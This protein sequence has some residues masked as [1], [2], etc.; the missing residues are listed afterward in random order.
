MPGEAKA[1][2]V[3]LEFLDAF[4]D[5]GDPDDLPC[6]FESLVSVALV[7]TVAHRFPCG[8]TRNQAMAF[9]PAII[10]AY[11]LPKYPKPTRSSTV[12]APTSSIASIAP[13]APPCECPSA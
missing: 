4:A 1:T 13:I 9:W 5:A 2:E 11:A 10:R 3:T 6:W 8:G 7:A 12:T